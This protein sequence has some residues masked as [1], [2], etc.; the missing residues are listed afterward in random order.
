MRAYVLTDRSL[1]RQAGRFVWLSINTE[2]PGN[3]P[4]LQK[5]PVQAWPTYFVIDARTEK[6]A[7]RW[8]GGATV[9]GLQKLLDEGRQA[10]APGPSRL[11]ATL[12]EADRLYGEGKNR[13]AA[14][15]Y[16]N[17]LSLAPSGWPQYGRTVESLLFA[18]TVAQEN[19]ACARAA[20]EAFPRL[21]HTPSAADVAASGLSCAL[22]LP[23]DRAGR[24]EL[25]SELERDTR[26]A[27]ADP[28]I[29]MS[30][31]DRSGMYQ[32]LIDAR[33]DAG[34][35]AG[36]DELIRKWSAFLDGEA[37]RARTAEERAVFDSHRLSAYLA[38]GTPEK[39]LPMLE[40]SERSLPNDYNPPARL[41]IAYKAMGRYDDAL[42]ASDRALARA[43]GP[44]KLGILRVRAEIFEARKQPAAA[45]RTLKEAIAEA[46][47]M[48]PG[49][50]SDR[51]IAALKRRLEALGPA[52]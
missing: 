18:L 52:S 2:K 31:D 37:A 19:D 50:R 30:A 12:A 24:P 20:R 8:V 23:K 44:R 40:A 4:F 36:K 46:E 38:L 29:V 1:T 43:Y 34:D 10:V 13:E 35:P 51:T 33:D 28:R 16:E 22:E 6:A 25:V 11:D 9:A 3:A 45:R 48:P 21:G 17:V 42:A 39:A 47:R 7:L 27:L 15:A 26:A 41:A 5:Y 49:Q 14:R 32:A